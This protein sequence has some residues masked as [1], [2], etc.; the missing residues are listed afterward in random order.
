MS[1]FYK[2][3]YDNFIESMGLFGSD[4]LYDSFRSMLSY[5]KN[6]IAL[7]RRI[8]EKA[9]DAS[10]VESIETGLVYV[11]NVMRNPRKTIENVEEVVPIALSKKI[12]VDSIKHLAQHTDLIQSV[13]PVTGKITPSKVLNVHKEESLLTYE[14]KFVNTLIDRLYIFVNRRYD[15]LKEVSRDEEVFALEYNTEVEAGGGKRMNMTLKL[16]TID[17][18]ETV[19]AGGATMWERVE[20]IKKII[21]SY[22]ASAFCQQMGTNYIRPPVMRTNAIM[23]NVDLK[24]CLTLWQFIESYDKVGYEIT[25]SD[26][27]Q[28]P[29]GTYIEDLYSLTA[30]NFLLF[31][32]FTQD[33]EMELE[34][35]RTKKSKAVSPKILRKFDKEKPEQYDMTL[36]SGQEKPQEETAENIPS[37]IDEILAQLDE[38]ILIERSFF[39][40]KE[41]KRIEAEERELRRQE[42]EKRKLEEQK[43]LEEERRLAQERAEQEEKERIERERLEAE[44]LERERLER[45]EQE[46][47]EAERIERERLE[48][49]E[50]ERQAAEREKISELISVEREKA[51]AERAARQAEQERIQREREEREKARAEKFRAMRN[52]LEKKDFKLIYAEYSRKPH[53]VIRREIAYIISNLRMDGKIIR[54]GDTT[55]P[56]LAER[57]AAEAAKKREKE[58]YL[59]E[60]AQMAVLFEKYAPNARQRAK[61]RLKRLFSKKKKKVYV[62]PKVMPIQR[63]PEEQ[64]AYDKQIKA[65][66]KTYHV[67]VF[68]KIKRQFIELKNSFKRNY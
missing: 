14:N 48:K 31:R 39:E 53:H 43:R 23:K 20:K 47:L 65:L 40:D 27:A 41:R 24:A 18:L 55:M 6:T 15:K 49:E 2:E 59:A 13:D 52:E 16:E 3:W 34:T 67:S 42:E 11:D 57:V 60:Q 8:M 1:G 36:A 56:M 25:V 38:I 30:L 33:K 9:I 54:E 21:E 50:E 26:S 63:T 46:R 66:F 22:K 44:R 29:S 51:E 62:M 45:E 28:K 5:G 37:E 68:E 10:W 17:S 58:R 19:G 32:S 7:N 61:K 12:T 4:E 64:K 35:L